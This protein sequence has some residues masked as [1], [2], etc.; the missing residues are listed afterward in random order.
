[1]SFLE[2]ADDRD[3]RGRLGGVALPA[4]S[5]RARARGTDRRSEHAPAAPPN[6]TC[7]DAGGQVICDTFVADYLV[8]EPIV[9]FDLPC[10]AIY[11][12]SHNHGAGTRW[13]VDGLVVRRHVAASFEGTWSLSPTG[14]A[15]TVS[16]TSAYSFWTI[17]TTPGD[18]STAVNTTSTGNDA[19]LS[20]R[21]YG[22]IIQS[23]GHTEADGTQHGL[24]FEVPFTPEVKAELCAALTA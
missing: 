7:R 15:P 8:N 23:A 16:N 13:Y 20:A 11:E 1:M 14:S 2:L 10:G 24:P 9:E 21:G 12:T 5:G 3:D 4:G 22:V 6:A 17:W 18:D 19:K